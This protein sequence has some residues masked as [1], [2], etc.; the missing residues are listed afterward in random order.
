MKK[1][2][3]L[4][5]GAG[6]CLP[7]NFKAGLDAAT[8]NLTTKIDDQSL[9]SLADRQRI[10]FDWNRTTGDYPADDCL[11]DAFSRL[12]IQTPNAPALIV[13]EKMVSYCQL[14]DRANRLAHFLKTRGTKPGDF[15]GVC[16]RRSTD[17]IA[18]VL[19]ITKIGA[20]YVPLDP[21]YPRERLSFMLEDSQVSVVLSQWALLDRLSIAS[22]RVVNLE[23]I[24]PELARQPNTDPERS[25]TP[26]AVAY[27]I[28][29]SGSTG[30]PK[31]V[32]VRHRAAI[33]TIHWVNQTFRIGQHDRLLFITSLSFDLSVYDIFGV[34]GVGGCL[35]VAD[36]HELKDPSKLADLLQTDGITLWNSAPAALQQLIPFL[37]PLRPSGDLKTVML[38]GDWIPV[39]LPGEVCA[40]FPNA[41]VMALGGATEA[42]IWSNWF[43]ITKV[44]PKWTS[45]PY[46]KP[47][48]NA[49]YHILDAKLEPVPVGT[50]GELHI[51]GLCLA[52]GYWQRPD[53]TAERF[54]NDPFRPGER[55]YKTGDLARYMPDGNIEFLGRIDLQVKIRGFRVELGE[56][57][58]AL[59][60]H[61]SVR[62]AIVKPFRDESGNISL[63]GFVVRK[64]LVEGIALANHLRVSLP[65]HMVPANFVFLDALPITPN[66]KVDRTALIQPTTP[67]A[68]GPGEYS[69]P[70]NDAELGVQR[71]WEE[72]LHVQPVSV[73]TRFE[74]LG[75]HSLMAAQIVSRIET[76]LGHKLPL[77]ALFHAATIREQATLIERKLE[78]GTGSLVPLNEKGSHHPLFLIAG[79][80]GHVFT[81]HKFSRCLGAEYPAYG[82]KAIGVDGSE[83][84]LD[85]VEEIAS[86]Y[87]EEIVKVRPKGPYIVSGYSVGGLMAF[88][89]ALQMQKRGLEVAKVIALDTFAPGY[90]KRLSW[91]TRLG[92]HIANFLSRP[93][94]RK[95]AY[96][97]HR[98]R[99]MRHR[100]LTLAG[101]NHLDLPD[102][103]K[104]GGVSEM[105]LKKV[106]AAQERARIHYWPER[107][108]DGQIVLVRSEAHEHWAATRLDDPLNGW[109]RWT[110]Q[111]VQVLGTPARHMELFSDENVDL[112]VQHIRDA[113]KFDRKK[114]SRPSSRETVVMGAPIS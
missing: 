112:L 56:V 4:P 41:G 69:A 50:L 64:A 95:W 76:R 2:F 6:F 38:S 63:T 34:L 22:D 73:T 5:S 17:M 108:F 45:I 31:G 94:E 97:A 15:V 82:M 21:A 8:A 99:N 48:R 83:P 78:I 51:G 54:I 77:E 23:Q 3:R 30:K 42:A 40:N 19:A 9:L 107:K 100:L 111:P 24:G 106:W 85:R 109:A 79:A 16:L 49:R 90:P 32:V 29:T 61:P 37:D 96:L 55:L 80:G 33:N 47:I 7:R 71:I 57:E 39:T 14:L 58:A 103:P 62:D 60:Q 52:N 43:P 89:L 92:I 20:A 18:A 10:V 11:P 1:C 12:A 102:A 66:G 65:D 110:T 88:E 59:T 68:A 105:V 93:G 53:L 67:T 86:R 70:I 25:H 74:E 114:T 27:V 98:I 84:P 13:D 75:G 113:I 81:F 36:E 46:G 72:V 26:D 101:L 44:D 87:L 104:I 28:Y 91:P 35:R